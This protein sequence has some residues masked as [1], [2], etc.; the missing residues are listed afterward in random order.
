M[1]ASTIPRVDIQRAE[2]VWAEY[3]ASHDMSA[4]QDKA[5]AIEPQ[6]KRVWIGNSALELRDQIRAAG[7]EAPVYLVRVGSDYYLRKGGRR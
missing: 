7:V 1:A 3:C 2:E 5:A 6:S 4:L